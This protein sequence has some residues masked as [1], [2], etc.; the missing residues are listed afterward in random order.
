LV[1]APGVPDSAASLSY[2]YTNEL[3]NSLLKAYVYVEVGGEDPAGFPVLRESRRSDAD[4][5]FRK[6]MYIWSTWPGPVRTFGSWLWGCYS[7]MKGVPGAEIGYI[8]PSGFPKF[9]IIRFK[10]MI[11]Q[12]E[13]ANVIRR[14][15]PNLTSKV[16]SL[17]RNK[18][19]DGV[20]S[21]LYRMGHG[22]KSIFWYWE[23]NHKLQYYRH[24]RAIDL[25]EGER[26]FREQ[27]FGPGSEW[28]SEDDDDDD[29]DEDREE[30]GDKGTDEERHRDEPEN[31]HE[32]KH[33][34]E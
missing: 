8:S 21:G 5:D 24:F 33:V 11:K 34:P 7:H 23:L 32:G 29:G 27:D 9:D 12:R 10:A 3:I 28:G 2:P 6:R 15:H 4:C 26:V 16:K 14:Y 13:R 19:R 30:C 17:F 31:E 18:S 1:L 20:E 22:E 25:V